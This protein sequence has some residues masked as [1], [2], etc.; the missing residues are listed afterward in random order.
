MTTANI[1]EL[2]DHLSEFLRR[3]EQGDEVV[4]TKRNIPFAAIVPLPRRQVNRT[5][6]GCLADTVVVLGDLTAPA[7][8]ESDWEMH[9][10]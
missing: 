10:P 6:L 8:P 9:G 4:I 5:K 1:S 7:I 2:K 3:V